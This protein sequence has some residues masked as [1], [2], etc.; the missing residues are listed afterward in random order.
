SG[1]ASYA[2]QNGSTDSVFTVTAPGTYF[3]TAVNGCGSVYRDTVQV[4]AQPPLSLSLGADRSKCNRDSVLLTAPEGFLRYTWSPGGETAPLQGRQVK[5]GPLETTTY[6]LTAE[7]TPGC[8]AY[9]TLVVRVYTSPEIRLGPDTSICRNDSLVL[10]AGPGFVW[11]SWSHYTRQPRQLVADRPGT[12][13]VIA[14]TAQGCFSTDTLKLLKVHNLPQPY[15][16]PDSIVCSG[17]SRVL[18]TPGTYRAYNWSTGAATSTITV[19]VAGTYWLSVTD[20]NGCRAADTT[21]IP[22]VVVSPAGFL[23]P[24]A[25]ICSYGSLE[26][27]AGGA[28]S[29]YAWNTGA[30][31]SAITVTQP[32]TYWLEVTDRDNCTGRDSVIVRLKNCME[33]VYVPNAFTPNGDGLNDVFKAL[34]YGNVR[35]YSFQVYDR[36]GKV[37]FQTTTPGTGWN[38]AYRGP[39]PGNNV[40]FWV[41]SYELNGKMEHQKGTVVLLP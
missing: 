29:A 12:Y 1:F 39:N 30:A 16:G 24:D 41:C 18:R 3:L 22:A 5:V 26:L 38:G 21:I 27:Q 17:Q 32:G 13:W 7:K 20:T 31:G 14:Q 4:T 40:F 35:S 11:Y 37:V 19:G 8:F 15:L 36:S 9:D 34:V 33:G 28:F 6:T 10:D 2:W 23:G 25:S